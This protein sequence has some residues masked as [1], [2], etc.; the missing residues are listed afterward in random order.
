VPCAISSPELRDTS[1]GSRI[2]PFKIESE[3]LPEFG[4]YHSWLILGTA[5]GI[6][7]AW[8]AT[9]RQYSPAPKF[10]SFLSSSCSPQFASARSRWY[11]NSLA[12]YASCWRW[13]SNWVTRSDCSCGLAN[14]QKPHFPAPASISDW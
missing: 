8:F 3:V 7:P 6:R 11:H 5:Y 12:F 1:D 9:P 10:S 13:H 14:R 2:S 4:E